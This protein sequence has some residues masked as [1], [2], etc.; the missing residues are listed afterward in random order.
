MTRLAIY[1]QDAHPLREAISHTQYAESKGFEAV[2]QADSRLVR[3]ASVPM[4]AFG[5]TTYAERCAPRPCACRSQ[6]F[7]NRNLNWRSGATS[8]IACAWIATTRTS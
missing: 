1:L 8:E 3:E 7:S 6:P 5:A 4:A 2:W